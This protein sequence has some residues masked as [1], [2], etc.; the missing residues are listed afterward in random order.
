[1]LGSRKERVEKGSASSQ[2]QR[3]TRKSE[4]SDDAQW[5]AWGKDSAPAQECESMRA[6]VCTVHKTEI[7]GGHRSSTSVRAIC[8]EPDA[9][10]RDALEI[11]LPH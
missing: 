4:V 3:C 7:C 8:F 6:N 5:P 10:N 2:R 1:M 9:P 11:D